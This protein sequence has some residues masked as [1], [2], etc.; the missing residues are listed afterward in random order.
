MN[1]MTIYKVFE[2]A[3]TGYFVDFDKKPD[4]HI[5]RWLSAGVDFSLSYGVKC[6]GK[7]V[8]FILHSPREDFVMNLATGVLKDHRGQG[9]VGLM[10]ER[11]KK[12]LPQKNMKRSQL[13]VITENQPAIRAYEKAG[14]LKKRKLLSWKG[15]FSK[16]T[17]FPGKHEIRP[18]AFTAEHEKLTPFP[19]AFEQTNPV[20]LKRSATLEL[21]ELW[22]EHQLLAYAVWN[23]WQMNV[24]QLGG[25]SREALKGLLYKMKLS[26]LHAG[27]VNVDEKN[28]LVNDVFRQS[29]LNNYLSQY[30]MEMFL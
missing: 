4:P 7:L 2:S 27:M 26:G 17:D 10:Y 28:E 16:I 15:E 9:L 22:G 21:H 11:M 29:G 18:V 24:I 30:E 19:Y 20:V 3:F 5:Q 8:A 6:D 12:D 23:P 25:I 13:E 14:F 1:V